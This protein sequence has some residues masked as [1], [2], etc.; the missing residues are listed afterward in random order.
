MFGYVVIILCDFAMHINVSIHYIQALGCV[1]F[2]L[3]YYEH[4]FPE[5]AKMSILDAKYKIPDKNRY[6][7]KVTKLLKMMFNK[8][9][10]KRPTCKQ[11]SEHLTDILCGG[12]GTL[13]SKSKKRSNS[14]VVQT[15]IH[16]SPKQNDANR[17]KSMNAAP[18]ELKTDVIDE[19]WDPFDDDDDDDPFGGDNFD[20]P[21]QFGLYS[22]IYLIL[23]LHLI[24]KL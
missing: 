7:K 11:I 15:Q 10:I 13:S 17:R 16:L 3:A 2:L 14:N 8:D 22:K 1:L 5:G 9:P 19:G 24:Y 21:F 20:N 6:S 12:K 4:P 23:S 18:E